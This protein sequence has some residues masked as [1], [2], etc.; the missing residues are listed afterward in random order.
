VVGGSVPRHERDGI[1]GSRDYLSRLS[2]TYE[3][4]DARLAA[5]PAVARDASYSLRVSGADAHGSN[6]SGSET[7]RPIAPRTAATA[8][9]VTNDSVNAAASPIR[10]HMTIYFVV[11]AR[12]TK[13]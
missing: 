6:S 11:S 12:A 4:L 10:I 7:E 3:P 13:T 1:T 5:R 8:S 2:S 9:P